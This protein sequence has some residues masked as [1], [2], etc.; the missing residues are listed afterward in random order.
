MGVPCLLERALKLVC[1]SP[2]EFNTDQQRGVQRVST[3]QHTAHLVCVIAACAAAGLLLQHV[4]RPAIGASDSTCMHNPTP[5]TPDPSADACTDSTVQQQVVHDKNERQ[6]LLAVLASQPATHTAAHL[7]V[8]L[9][10]SA[11]GLSRVKSYTG[12]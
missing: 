7:H 1:S 11:A 8:G 6:H 4:A 2:E 9:A 10:E 3:P 12:S 5:E